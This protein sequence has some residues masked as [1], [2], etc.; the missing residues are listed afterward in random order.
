[1]R[2][3]KCDDHCS[4]QR[5]SQADSYSD[6]RHRRHNVSPCEP[7]AISVEFNE[8]MHVVLRTEASLSFTSSATCFTSVQADGKRRS[9]MTEMKSEEFEYRCGFVALL[10]RPNVGKSSLINTLLKEKVAAVSSKP[11]TIGTPYG[12][13]TTAKE[14]GVF[15]DTPGIHKPKNVLGDFMLNEAEKALSQVDLICSWSR[16]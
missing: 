14:Q 12:I 8:E 16:P 3:K 6:S 4:V 15:V 9:K 13:M 10:G 7:V 1:M 5:R 2:G 11:Q